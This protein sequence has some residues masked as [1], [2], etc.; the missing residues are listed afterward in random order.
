MKTTIEAGLDYVKQQRDELWGIRT[1]A[2]TFVAFVAA[3]SAFLAGAGLKDA[4]RNFWFFVVAGIGTAAFLVLAWYVIRIVVPKDTFATVIEPNT[5]LDWMVGDDP[6]PTLEAA[7][8]WL[9]QR[10]LPDMIEQNEKKL[11]IVRTRYKRLLLTG[12]GTVV[13]WIILVWVFA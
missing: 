5:I 2:L 10:T 6:R 4:T 12:T 13:I 11:A 8:L 1:R 9:V 7:Q 3:A